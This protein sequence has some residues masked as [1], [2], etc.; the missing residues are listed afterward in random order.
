MGYIHRIFLTY[1][2]L[3]HSFPANMAF[4]YTQFGHAYRPTLR[5]RP[6]LLSLFV[7][8]FPILLSA[9]VKARVRYLFD[10]VPAMLLFARKDFIIYVC[11]YDVPSVERKA[12]KYAIEKISYFSKVDLF[13][14]FAT[15]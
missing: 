8:Y 6:I 15:M 10:A 7:S 13:M 12:I 11:R 2:C 3:L 9:R 5:K 1:F 14:M 4:S